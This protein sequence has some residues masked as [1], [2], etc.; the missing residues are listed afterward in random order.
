[1]VMDPTIFARIALLSAVLAISSP[2]VAAPTPA[3]GYTIYVVQSGDTLVS[4]AAQFGTTT[5]NLEQ[6]NHLADP[7]ALVPGQKLQVPVKPTPTVAP[8]APPVASANASTYTVQKGDTLAAIAAHF[9]VAVNDLARAN[10]IQNV[11]SLSIGQVLVIPS[12]GTPLPDGIA[13]SP[14]IVRQGNTIEFKITA[15]DVVSATGTFAGGP[16]TFVSEN[17]TLFALAGVS[18]C[19]DLT[20][21]PAKITARTASGETRNLVFDVR[22]NATN[23]PVQ[24]IT[25]TPQMAALLDPAIERAENARVAATVAPVTPQPF[26]NGAFRLPLNVKDPPI[27]AEFGQRRSYNGGPVGACGHEGEDFAVDGGTPVYAPAAGTIALAEPLKVRGNVIFINHGLGVY[28][29][30][31]HLSKIEVQAGQTVKPGDLLGEV[32]TTGFST[33]DHLHWSM[34]VNGV[35][36]DPIAWTTRAIP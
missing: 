32:G 23:F 8:T 5:D 22:V 18:R 24:N 26:W 33:G 19:A 2:N 31:Y 35:Y 28:S 7:T 30:F 13:L 25:L 20:T 14:T 29:G 3:A 4:I 15:S 34:W 17:G 6:A 21:Y 27:S 9:G 10:H 1:M 16:L 12:T 36:V 11:D